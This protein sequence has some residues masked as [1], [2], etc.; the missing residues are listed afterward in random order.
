MRPQRDLRLGGFIDRQGGINPGG[1]Y[2]V[3]AGAGPK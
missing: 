1:D 3:A 2:V